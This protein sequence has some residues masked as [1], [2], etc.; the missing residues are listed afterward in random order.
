MKKIDK[1]TITTTL[2][3]PRRKYAPNDYAI[4]ISN[5]TN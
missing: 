4:M 3:I 1:K 2:K 5:E